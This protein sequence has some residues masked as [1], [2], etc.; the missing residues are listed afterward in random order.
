MEIAMNEQISETKTP[1]T[2]KIRSRALLGTALALVLGGAVVGGIVLPSQTPALA[3][4]VQVQGVQ[5]ISFADVVEKVRPAVVSVRVKSEAPEAVSGDNQD[6]PFFDLPDGSPMQKFFKQFRQGPGQ[7]RQMPNRPAMSLGSGF[8]ISDDGYVV[9]NNHVIE[10][11]QSVTVVM[12]D[13]TEYPAKVIGKDD[14][15]DLALLKVDADKKFTYVKF[16]EDEIRVGDWVV[17]VGN[18]FGLGGT[19]TAGIVSAHG[20]QIGAGPYDD[21]IQI[22]AAVNRGNS[23]GPAFNF[24]G[25]VVG[26]NTAIFSPSGGNVG[27]AFA[28]PAHMAEHIV[29]QIK[30]HGSVV[31]G[32]LGV[33]IQQVNQDIADSLRLS[34]DKGALVTEAQGDSPA[35]KAG[36]KSGDTILAVNGKA[37]DGPRELAAEI[38]DMAPGSTV[39]LTYWR[40]GEKHDLDVT[41][42]TYPETQEQA[43]VETPSA[44]E[45]SA[46][47][48]FG[49]SIA[50]TDDNQGVI[51]TDVDPN[52]QAAERGLQPG[53]VILAV[54]DTSVSDPA[55]VEKKMAD[56]KA[57][58]LK[59]VLLRVKS[60]DQTR[61]VALSFAQA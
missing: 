33:Q 32:W 22:D 5:P 7:F 12:D 27:I 42:G 57:G 13:G 59:A 61:F 1:A 10:K 55:A 40:G 24:R 51:V 20:R 30:D 28:I 26:V 21:F 23:G 52:G 44:V 18:P 56:A 47:E 60:G 8:F 14:K 34:E 31:R 38:A 45:P 49:M 19:V 35:A 50:P 53:D 58:G 3:E 4:A 17:A 36:I 41:L 15:T 29:D 43:S 46:L 16:A 2:R 9:T 39:K 48:D 54:G 6:F 37:V 11:E 25:E